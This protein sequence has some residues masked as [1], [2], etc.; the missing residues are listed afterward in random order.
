VSAAGP[1]PDRR[2]FW[3]DVRRDYASLWPEMR[4]GLLEVREQWRELV[5]ERRQYRQ[6]TR[7]MWQRITGAPDPTR[8]ERRRASRAIL[9]EAA[10]LEAI[11]R[12]IVREHQEGEQ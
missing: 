8:R 9:A 3:A 1:P 12:R 7:R 10:E 4:R 5:A 11:E 2:G 6:L